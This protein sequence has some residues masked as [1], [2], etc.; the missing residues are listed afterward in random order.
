MNPN[1][2]EDNNSDVLTCAVD[3]YSFGMVMWEVATGQEPFE[4]FTDEREV[5]FNL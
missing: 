5:G 1:A 2:T 3:V 4:A